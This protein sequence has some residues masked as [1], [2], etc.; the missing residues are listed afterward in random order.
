MVASE[1]MKQP[2]FMFCRNVVACPTAFEIRRKPEGLTL[3]GLGFCIE[4]V[5]RC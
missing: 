4:L 5:R 2:C 1:Q 3:W